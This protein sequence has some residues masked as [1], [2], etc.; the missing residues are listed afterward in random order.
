MVE[1]WRRCAC[2]RTAVALAITMS[3]ALL[4]W[5]DISPSRAVIWLGLGLLLAIAFAAYV[6][7]PV[8]T[9]RVLRARITEVFTGEGG[10]ECRAVSLVTG[11]C[12]VWHARPACRGHYSAARRYLQRHGCSAVATLGAASRLRSRAP[13]PTVVGQRRLSCAR[14]S[15]RPPGRGSAV[16]V[17]IGGCRSD[18]AAVS[19]CRSR[20]SYLTGELMVDINVRLG[21]QRMRGSGSGQHL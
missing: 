14:P 4:L 3:P 21:R 20:R 19:Y 13:T 17:I 15:T 5:R 7:W 10:P 12:D 2:R 8:N 1:E 9:G 6:V 18:R 16:E 11:S